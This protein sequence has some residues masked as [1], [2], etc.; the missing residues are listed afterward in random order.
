MR[1]KSLKLHTIAV[2]LVNNE[3]LRGPHLHTGTYQVVSIPPT[4]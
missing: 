4:W 2:L 3:A 1:K